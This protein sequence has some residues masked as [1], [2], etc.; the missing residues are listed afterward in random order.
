M[1][2]KEEYL[3]LAFQT[4][5]RNLA[6]RL[7]AEATL[8]DYLVETPDR[9]ARQVVGAPPTTASPTTASPS[10]AEPCQHPPEQR[11]ESV[12]WDPV[13]ECM[14]TDI[15]CLACNQDLLSSEESTT[16]ATQPSSPLPG[17]NHRF[18]VG[19]PSSCAIHCQAKAV[20]LHGATYGLR[21]PRHGVYWGLWPITAQDAPPTPSTSPSTGSG[22]CVGGSVDGQR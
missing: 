8:C 19:R 20:R 15:D 16:P 13:Q 1:D 10:A 18:Y 14:V 7:R 17:P 22:G 4:Q 5:L 3:R 2:E 9:D 12:R 21:C 11:A 6:H